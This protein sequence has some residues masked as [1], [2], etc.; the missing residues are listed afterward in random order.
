VLPE[1]A[2]ATVRLGVVVALPAEALTLA[3]GRHAPGVVLE[4]GDVLL[5]VS[6]VGP[7]RA[8]RAAEALLARGAAALASWGSAGGLDPAVAVGALCLPRSV[9][10]AGGQAFDADPAWH[11][12]LAARLAGLPLSTGA[13]LESARV[14][15]TA[16]E[17]QAAFE[18]SGALAVDM[19][20]ASVAAA[21]RAAGC[22]FLAV[23]A[24]SDAA[25]MRV[26]HASL[27]AFDAEGRLRLGGLA[28]ALARRPGDLAALVRLDL[29][30][31]SAL[32]SLR[33]AARRAGPGLCAG[34][35]G[36]G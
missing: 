34:G 33:R 14:L 9:L 16:A 19:E 6:G 36:N 8:R 11:A 26:P 12:R 28:L 1:P 27:R 20:S 35:S 24:V 13:L 29:G 2:G 7:E 18:A 3:G 31:R 15:A 21:A 10:A 4:Q 22:P 25:R 23:R 32:A 17:K 5:A 30:F